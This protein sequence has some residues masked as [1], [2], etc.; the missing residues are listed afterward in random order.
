MSGT[1]VI[2]DDSDSL[3][4]ILKRV[5]TQ[6]GY[7]TIL[8]S[9]WDRHSLQLVQNLQPVLV[10]T[11]LMFGLKPLGLQIVADLQANPATAQIPILVCSGNTYLLANFEKSYQTNNKIKVLT[12][13]Y[14]I[15]ELFAR[16]A[17]LTGHHP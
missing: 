16:I 6:A 12:K 2:I 8:H 14:T 5:L 1:I 3:L 10:I 4:Q 13:P 7:I 15:R 17:D 9:T 11:D